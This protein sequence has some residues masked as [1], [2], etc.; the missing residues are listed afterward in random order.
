MAVLA[1]S[2]QIVV[3]RVK[4]NRPAR[5]VTLTGL[6]TTEIPDSCATIAGTPVTRIAAARSM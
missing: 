6:G 2:V 3:S 5:G 1:R 4:T